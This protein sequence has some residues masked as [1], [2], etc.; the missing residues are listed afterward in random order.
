MSDT[1]DLRA[2]AGAAHHDCQG[3]ECVYWRALDHLG[4]SR[5]NGCAIE[6][7]ELLGDS[8]VTLWLLSVKERLEA[9]V[10]SR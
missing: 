7:Y 5:G 1:C 4:T 6:H 10:A 2:A 9:G 8:N 3:A